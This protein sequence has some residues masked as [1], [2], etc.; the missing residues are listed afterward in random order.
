MDEGGCP[1][2]QLRGEHARFQFENSF[3]SN[4]YPKIHGFDLSIEPPWRDFEP[5]EVQHYRLTSAGV[6]A[7]TA[8]PPGVLLVQVHDSQFSPRVE[9]PAGNV[10]KIDIDII[11]TA[12][13]EFGEE[14][15]IVVE[16]SQLFPLTYARQDRYHAGI[17]FI[18]FL[19]IKPASARIDSA[20]RVHF[21]PFPGAMIEEIIA[22]SIEP[23]HLFMDEK[24]TL[25]RYSKHAWAYKG[26]RGALRQKFSQLMSVS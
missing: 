15:G 22:L 4:G 25:L 21:S 18:A 7:L 6:L 12:Q 16:S 8:K 20:G 1:A 2:E 9:I 26:I 5:D 3:I 14:T 11:R 24:S 19:D 10:E 23:F 17:Q 13:R